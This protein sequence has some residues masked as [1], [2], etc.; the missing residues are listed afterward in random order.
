MSF[1]VL[2]FIFLC[3]PANFSLLKRDFTCPGLK[4]LRQWLAMSM[5][6]RLRLCQSGFLRRRRLESNRFL[7]NKLVA[8]QSNPLPARG[9]DGGDGLCE[10]NSASYAANTRAVAR[11]RAQAAVAA[12]P[13][14]Y[15]F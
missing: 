13:L 14:P 11:R 1:I 7:L 5:N 3:L 15:R 2:R 8:G 12:Y 9:D 6:V 10:S 4:M